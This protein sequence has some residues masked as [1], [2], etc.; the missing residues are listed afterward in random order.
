MASSPALHETAGLLN[1]VSVLA[2][3][4]GLVG[5]IRLLRGPRGALG[6]IGAGLILVAAVV[7]EAGTFATSL[8]QAAAVAP[9]SIR[10]QVLALIVASND[11]AFAQ[12][13]AV[14]FFGGFVLGSL[15]LA[16]GLIRRHAVPVWAATLVFVQV[17]VSFLASN[18]LIDA[19]A[20]L[21]LAIGFGA[22]AWTILSL[23]NEQWAAWQPLP[24]REAPAERSA[25]KP[26]EAPG[27]LA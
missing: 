1:L 10:S 23:S 25:P 9:G 3:I 18:N 8:I 11:S 4:V 21:V 6:R 17:V 7:L 12:V 13:F 16:V 20:D 22:I 5:V 2:F 27:A 14:A 15:L 19:L 24:D 26:S